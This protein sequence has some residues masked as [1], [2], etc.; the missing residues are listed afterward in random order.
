[1]LLS[2]Q[3]INFSFVYNGI[4]IFKRSGHDINVQRALFNQLHKNVF[5]QIQ[6]LVENRIY[7]NV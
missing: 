2:I 1:M 6:F 4:L 5:P 3:S 7:H